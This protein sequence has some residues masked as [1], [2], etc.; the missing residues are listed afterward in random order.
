MKIKTFWVAAAA[1]LATLN[2]QAWGGFGHTIVAYVAEQ[3]LTPET[4]AKCHQYLG[5]TLPYCA[6]WMDYWRSIP[7]YKETTYWH[8]CRADQNDNLIQEKDRCA[9][10]QITR[11]CK[12]LKN[13]KK[14]SN[15]QIELD[16][17][18]L[19]HMVGDM[20]C[21]SH[22]VYESKIPSKDIRVKGKKV[23]RHKFWDNSPNTFHPK[24]TAE[25]FYEHLDVATDK[26]IKKICKGS[27]EAWA[28][29]QANIMRRTYTLYENG[30]E[31]TKL[32][33]SVRNEMQAL[34]DDNLLKAGYRLAYLLNKIFAK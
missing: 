31:F 32:P 15:E 3:H 33:L 21:P 12:E 4:K 30:A 6:S 14:M 25:Q 13:Y 2:V 23:K 5:H 22:I 8:V 7:P 27:P 9:A 19:I 16:L 20:H 1:L 24:W 17:K 34:T 18:L 10:L 29:K 26:Q 28:T 11:I